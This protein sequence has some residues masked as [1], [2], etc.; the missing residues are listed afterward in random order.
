MLNGGNIA[1]SEQSK[2]DFMSHFPNLGEKYVRFNDW[3]DLKYSVLYNLND[4]SS[5]LIL[6]YKQFLYI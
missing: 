2:Q 3:T 1:T 5:N 4:D 6:P